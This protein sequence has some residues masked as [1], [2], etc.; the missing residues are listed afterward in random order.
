[1]TAEQADGSPIA[2]I[3][4]VDEMI[5]RLRDR[6]RRFGLSYGVVHEAD[7]DAF[8]PVVARRTDT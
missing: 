1:M 8:A 7:M 4:S 5:E 6:R 2:V 3:G